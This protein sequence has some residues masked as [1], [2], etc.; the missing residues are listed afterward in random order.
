MLKIANFLGISFV[1]FGSSGP[2]RRPGV[3]HQTT[4]MSERVFDAEVRLEPVLGKLWCPGL[5]TFVPGDIWRFMK[6][7][8]QF[9][10]LFVGEFRRPARFGFVVKRVVELALF[11]SIKKI[12]TYPRSPLEIFPVCTESP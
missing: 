2:P 7:C 5:D 8:F 10:E 12:R 1:V 4:D 3:I 9:V 6:S 11:E